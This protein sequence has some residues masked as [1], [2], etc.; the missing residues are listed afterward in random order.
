MVPK[1]LT[2]C[3][4]LAPPSSPPS[5][6]EKAGLLPLSHPLSRPCPLPLPRPASSSTTTS[7][8]CPS[9]RARASRKRSQRACLRWPRRA[10]VGGPLRAGL[11][12]PRSSRRTGHLWAGSW[13]TRSLRRAGLL[14]TS[15][16]PVLARGMVGPVEGA[17]R[18]AQSMGPP[19][20]L[21]L[22]CSICLWAVRRV[23]A[24]AWED[25]VNTCFL[26]LG[27]ISC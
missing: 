27:K 23:W 9:S 3:P 1:E 19:G 18:W 20:S 21:T 7:P 6:A 8:L 17:C 25:A 24:I 14:T 2:A 10:A 16:R 11:P 26:V 5:S 12:R 15:T 13:A 22:R 4:R